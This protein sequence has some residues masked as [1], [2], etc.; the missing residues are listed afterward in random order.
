MNFPFMLRLVQSCPWVHFPWPDPT[1]PNPWLNPTHGQLWD[2]CSFWHTNKRKVSLCCYTHYAGKMQRNTICR[3]KKLI[4]SPVKSPVPVVLKPKS[5][6][7]PWVHP[8]PGKM[9]AMPMEAELIRRGEHSLHWY[10]W[11]IFWHCRKLKQRVRLRVVH[12]SIF[13][14]PTQP[15]P[16]R[17]I[18][19]LC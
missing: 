7:T 8:P 17:A 1:Q 13:H 10:F 16:T 2:G 3:P 11:S 19:P 9:L 12:G 4:F 6:T 14:D 18:E 5:E 15:N